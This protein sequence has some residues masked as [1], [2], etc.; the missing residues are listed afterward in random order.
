MSYYDE[1]L[2]FC[3]QHNKI[4]CYGAGDFGTKVLLCLKRNGILPNAFLISAGGKTELDGIPVYPL[5]EI[6][7]ELDSDSGVILSLHEKHHKEVCSRLQQ[8]GIDHIFPVTDIDIHTKI[9]TEIS[10]IIL[11]NELMDEKAES[12]DMEDDFEKRAEKLL[13]QYSKVVLQYIYFK[14]IGGLSYWMY[15]SQL[16]D[17]D[18]SDRYYL[19]YPM[20]KYA[21]KNDIHNMPNNFLLKKCK[22][23]GIE[24]IS[25]ETLA[26]WQFFV[27]NYRERLYI[28]NGHSLSYLSDGINLAVSKG[29]VDVGRKYIHL[30]KAELSEG[31]QILKKLNLNGDFVCVFNRDSAYRRDI[32]GFHDSKL[33]VIDLYRNSDID[34]FELLAKWLKKKNISAVRM[35]AKCENTVNSSS[36]IIDYAATLRSDFGDVYLSSKCMFMIGDTSGIQV[37]PKLFAKPVITTN[38]YMLTSRVDTILPTHENY[39]LVILQKHWDQNRERYLTIREMIEMEI[40]GEQEKLDSH[41]PANTCLVYHRKG[42]KPIKNTPEEIL[43]VAKEMVQRLNGTIEY[44]ELDMKLKE[45]FDSIKKEY[46]RDTN[47]FINMRI[48]RDFLRQNQWLLE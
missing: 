4:Y 41:R 2:N 25:P 48:G 11:Y 13:E 18:K 33:D 34:N 44:N 16:R 40:N 31:E 12:Q 3:N 5:D 38:M 46:M 17:Q 29:E 24:V 10:D 27:K 36:E 20:S 28:P 42:I 43:D 8:L 47:F 23:D 30:S 9:A 26:F 35:G 21:E 32:M 45:K 7:F 39:D 15:Y 19:Y 6:D 22:G 14:H 1:L 37:F